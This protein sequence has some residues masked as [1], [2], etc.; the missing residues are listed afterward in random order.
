MASLSF[1][2]SK[3]VAPLTDFKFQMKQKSTFDGFLSAKSK[4]MVQH[5]AS[6]EKIKKRKQHTLVP[7]SNSKI[8]TDFHRSPQ[9][10]FNLLAKSLL[11]C[12]VFR[13][14]LLSILHKSAFICG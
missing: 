6:S 9:M 2:E 1:L 13:Q 8:S 5:S 12:F 14:C 4:R 11:K 3:K 10:G 7:L